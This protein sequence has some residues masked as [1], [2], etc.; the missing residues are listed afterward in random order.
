[1]ST[2]EENRTLTGPQKDLK[3]PCSSRGSY[4]ISVLLVSSSYN[5]KDHHIG[6][7]ET[8]AAEGNN[9]NARVNA[10]SN[11]IEG[12]NTV[13]PSHSYLSGYSLEDYRYI[14]E[15]RISEQMSVDDSSSQQLG[16]T[17]RNEQQHSQFSDRL[18]IQSEAHHATIEYSQKQ[19][20]GMQWV[21]SEEQNHLQFRLLNPAD[22]VTSNI[23]NS[24]NLDLQNN[25]FHRRQPVSL[26]SYI[27]LSAG[28]EPATTGRELP[29]TNRKVPTTGRE[30]QTTNREPLITDRE[31]STKSDQNGLGSSTHR[32]IGNGISHQISSLLIELMKTKDVEVLLNTTNEDFELKIKGKRNVFNLLNNICFSVQHDHEAETESTSQNIVHEVEGNELPTDSRG[33]IDTEELYQQDMSDLSENDHAHLVLDPNTLFNHT[34]LNDDSNI[35]ILS[36]PVSDNSSQTSGDLRV[37]VFV[38]SVQNQSSASFLSLRY[39]YHNSQPEDSATNNTSFNR[40]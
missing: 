26:N 30:P 12:A 14:S 19:T 6:N 33:S 22:P 21:P 35:T 8:F 23:V 11:E 25:F 18:S 10:V 31:H 36:P 5:T 4:I 9:R 15:H 28:R 3:I 17:M 27:N 2:D 37:P 16:A 20:H 38:E 13:R 7:P 1:M 29:K 32:A 40:E 34:V 39:G 24:D